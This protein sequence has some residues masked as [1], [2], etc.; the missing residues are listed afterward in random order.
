[1]PGSQRGYM[2]F[3]PPSSLALVPSYNINQLQSLI[4]KEDLLVITRV[5][6]FSSFFFF[7]VFFFLIFICFSFY[8]SK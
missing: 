5:L 1:M 2:D 8:I 3:S 4:S 7:V 6:L